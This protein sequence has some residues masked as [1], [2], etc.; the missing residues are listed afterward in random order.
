MIYLIILLI[1]IGLTIGLVFWI[2]YLFR[3][4][5]NKKF[6]SF[7]I[8]FCILAIL[9]VFVTWELQIFPLS[10]N[11]YIKKQTTKL[12]GKTFWSWKEFSYDEFGVRGEGYCL[13][14]YKFSQETADYFLTP[15][16]LFFLNYPL[17]AESDI[18]WTPTPVKNEDIKVLNFVTPIYGNWTGEIVL[19]QDF[20]RKLATTKGAFYAYKDGGTTDFYIISPKNRLVILINHDM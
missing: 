9:T 20:I 11:F 18:K 10:E 7:I 4:L 19:K 13:Y 3:L 12:T 8:Q 16:S 15:D 6:K 2:I 17:K 1:L 5:V 14:I